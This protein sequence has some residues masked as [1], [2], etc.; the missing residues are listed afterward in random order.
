MYVRLSTEVDAMK[1][2]APQTD[3]HLI[4]HNDLLF[5]VSLNTMDIL[6]YFLI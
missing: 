5:P 1:P 3:F 6:F 2:S 4:V